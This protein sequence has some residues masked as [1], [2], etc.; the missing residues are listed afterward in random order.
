MLCVCVCLDVCMRQPCI[1]EVSIPM[2]SV[3]VLCVSVC[4]HAEEEGRVIWKKSRARVC[5][6]DRQA[7][8]RWSSSGFRLRRA[9]SPLERKVD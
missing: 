8:G 9:M 5:A 7:H 4:V 2:L 6:R 1:V 3:A